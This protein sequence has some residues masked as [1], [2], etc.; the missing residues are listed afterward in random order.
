M[1]TPD[2]TQPA[3]RLEARS[4]AQLLDDT[5]ARTPTPGGGSVACIVGALAAALAAMSVNYSLGRKSLAAH[6][7]AHRE[8]LHALA[9]ARSLLLE[10]AEEDAG[11]Y[12]ALN[13][14]M[15]LPPSDPTRAQRLPQLALDAARV[16][17][18]IVAACSDLL[19]RF[20]ALAPV[21]N[22]HLRSDLAIAG[23][24]AE[25]AAR[26][27]RWNI[28]VNAPLMDPGEARAM[29]SQADDLIASGRER[30]ARIE[31]ACSP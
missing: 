10:L 22:P 5:A 15:R 31:A 17:L 25:A 12:A 30:L 4:L 27:G 6:E 28:A 9:R 2:A 8:A 1:N 21:T 20:E 23:V 7:P 13:E 24:L 16:P 26:A 29:L 3:P 19:R 18:T 11:A 14:A